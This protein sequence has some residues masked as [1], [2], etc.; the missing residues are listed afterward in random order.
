MRRLLLL[1]A[2]LAAA[3]L[4]AVLVS[5]TPAAA[6][7]G[8]KV[9]VALKP[10]K[11]PDAMREEKARLAE[12]L[13]RRLGRPVEVVVPLSS[14]VIQEGL[15]GGSVDV[16]WLSSTDMWI[17]RKKGA[18]TMAEKTHT[19]KPAVIATARVGEKENGSKKCS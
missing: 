6:A 17:A 7:P 14:A 13:G 9:V 12:W 11:S 2:I 8:G 5:A 4:S 1:A 18:R 10:D 15:A 19:A 16:A 3:G